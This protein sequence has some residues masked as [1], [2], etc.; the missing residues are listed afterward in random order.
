MRTALRE[1]WVL[2]VPHRALLLASLLLIAL[3]RA[4]AVVLPGTTKFLID[5]VIGQ[6]KTKLLLPLVGAVVAA[7]AVQGITSFVLTQSLSKTAQRLIAELRIKVHAHVARLPV[8]YYDCN[9]TG[10]L[11]ARV[12]NDV[13]GIR[14]LLGTGLISF[15]GGI[16]TSVVALF[17]LFSISLFLTAVTLPILLRIGLRD[18]EEFRNLASAIS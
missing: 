5:G 11:T 13:E 2:A 12:M 1:L 15:I 9:A 7:T 18:L 10:G 14:T 6:H 3:N 8:A 4:A 16:L 17:V